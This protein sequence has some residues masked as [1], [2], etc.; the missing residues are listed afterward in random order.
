MGPSFLFCVVFKN[1]KITIYF[2]AHRNDAVEVGNVDDKRKKEKIAG[3]LSLS[4]QEGL[5]LMA[6]VEGLAVVGTCM[7]SI[8]P[9]EGRVYG[10]R[11]RG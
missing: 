8:V 3:M 9:E 7:S 2:C 10:Q 11:Y 6:H 1:G 4:R 5:R